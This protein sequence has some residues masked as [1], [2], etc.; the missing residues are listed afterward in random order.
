MPTIKHRESQAMTLHFALCTV[1]CVFLLA[2]C[3][4]EQEQQQGEVVLALAPDAASVSVSSDYAAQAIEAA[5]GLDAWT[6]AKELHLECVVTLYQPDGSYYL[7]QQVYQIYPWSNSIQISAA[8]PQGTIL[9]QL[10]RGQ[11]D[12]LQGSSQID[13]LSPAVPARCLAQAI[14]NIVTAPARFLDASAEFAKQDSAVKIQGQWY[15]PI[16]K[17][18]KSGIL[19]GER[20][21]KAVFYQ[22]RDSSLIDLL[23][24]A[25]AETGKSLAV[26]GYDYDQIEKS[27]L[28][29]PT[30]IE[31]FTTDRQGGS[32][33][34]LLKIDLSQG[35]SGEV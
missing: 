11:F 2:G 9:W 32:Q 21:A 16:E 7:S 15:H 1:V 24:V 12:V 26:R 10:S 3:Q 20:M 18:T 22:N 33:R 14:L 19:S 17:A 28:L 6:R 30:R 13:E 4:Q 35:R 34:R 25:C 8:E 23:E 31:V 5:G 27:G 29:V